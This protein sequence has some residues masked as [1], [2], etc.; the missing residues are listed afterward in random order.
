[1][2]TLIMPPCYKYIATSLTSANERYEF[3]KHFFD[4]LVSSGAEPDDCLVLY[5]SL[6][7]P[8][9]VGGV[10]EIDSVALNPLD[11]FNQILARTDISNISCP[12][13]YKNRLKPSNQNNLC[14]LC[15]LSRS[16]KQSNY[17]VECSIFK[18]IATSRENLVKFN[19]LGVD[20]VFKYVV[21]IAAELSVGY[22]AIVPILNI[23]Y[24]VICSQ[25]DDFYSF[26]DA[27]ERLAS[28]VGKV[29]VEAT[30]NS[31]VKKLQMENHRALSVAWDTLISDILSSDDISYEVL[32]QEVSKIDLSSGKKKNKKKKP[33]VPETPLF[34]YLS[35]VGDSE[36]SGVQNQQNG[37]DVSG[38]P[39]ATPKQESVPEQDIPS[40][41]DELPFETTDVVSA[42]Q[43]EYP[44]D[45]PE[46]SYSDADIMGEGDTY[47]PNLDPADSSWDG[48]DMGDIPAPDTIPESAY[49]D[50]AEN[51]TSDVQEEQEAQEEDAAENGDAPA[52][53]A[54]PVSAE[55]EVSGSPSEPP[56]QERR[57]L[58]YTVPPIEETDIIFNIRVNRN[59]FKHYANNYKVMEKEVFAVLQKSKRLPV[60]VIYDG[61][62]SAYLFMFIRALGQ[63][64]YCPIDSKMPKSI[65]AMFLS[66]SVIKICYQPYFLYSLL[67]VYDIRACGIYSICTVD[68][69]LHPEAVIGSYNDFFAVYAGD[70]PD[71]PSVDTGFVEFDNLLLN[72]QKY[73]LIH[74]RQTRTPFD[75]TEYIKRHSRDE[76]LGSSFLRNINLI[77]NDYLFSL[78]PSGRIIYNQNF[79]QRAHS[80]GFFVTY[81]IG[82]E[83][84]GTLE[85]SE[86]YLDALY[87][88]STKGRFRKYNIQL[89]TMTATAMV[90]F[91][92]EDEYELITTALQKYFNRY[93]L[94]HRLEK[95]ELNVAH[96]RIYYNTKKGAKH[97]QIPRTYEEAMDQLITTN[98]TVSVKETHIVKRGKTKRKRQTQSFKPT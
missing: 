30:R 50:N 71:I 12:Q 74:A 5:S 36:K 81:S 29:T 27:H 76:V 21:D 22:P 33:L 25:V 17:K 86:L 82:A 28:I 34:D 53:D 16:Y 72:M 38:G 48:G 73:I 51:D 42:P 54:E 57:V 67:R 46:E 61:D 19:E 3:S 96:Q 58:K 4:K 90:L 13:Y 94:S 89:V 9:S 41:D 75:K 45:M 23:A 62:G 84:I 2:G 6:S 98:D 32:C 47:N 39:T 77:S 8:E 7:M 24:S 37:N 63:F 95:F 1:M 10:Y 49:S 59:T 52:A 20:G 56:E 68:S 11:Y 18:Y 97:R 64:V 44:E 70:F 26:D 80:D 43:S 31:N 66:K 35:G 85:L 78:E 15:E 87:D 88:L 91:I 83:D 93:A 79:E 60:E 92:G 55:P 69:L 40:P 14:Q 65:I